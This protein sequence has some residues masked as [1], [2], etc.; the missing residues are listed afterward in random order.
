[1]T[2]TEGVCSSERTDR[3]DIRRLRPDASDRLDIT[4]LS[5]LGGR[6]NDG[7]STIS[8]CGKRIAFR[9]SR[10]GFFNLYIMDIDG[11][12]IRQLTDGL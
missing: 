1:V 12:N 9:S 3:A 6:T 10:N 4:K 7:M 8:P 2:F 5:G 11:A